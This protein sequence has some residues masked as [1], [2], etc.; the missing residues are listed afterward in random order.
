MFSKPIYKDH[1]I[2]NDNL[3]A[4]LNNIPICQI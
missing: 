2:F 3:I 4:A 1:V